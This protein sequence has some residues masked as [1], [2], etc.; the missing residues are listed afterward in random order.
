[1]NGVI[2]QSCLQQKA[3][4]FTH[5][6]SLNG[7]ELIMCRACINGG[8]EPRWNVLLHGRSNGWMSVQHLLAPKQLY[9]GD[10]IIAADLIK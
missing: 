8:Y 3:Q 4:L 5:K 1:M 2:C 10:P 7:L 9:F 6:S